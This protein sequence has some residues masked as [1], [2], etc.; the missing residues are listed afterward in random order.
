MQ[1]IHLKNIEQNNNLKININENTDIISSQKSVSEIPEGKIE[2][3]I[4]NPVKNQLKNTEQVKENIVKRPQLKK[5]ESSGLEIK[6]FKELIEIA[7]R[8][9]ELELKYDLE[10]NINLVSFTK[11]KININF[12]EKLNKNFIKNLTGK[13]FDWTGER[14]I[15]SLSKEEGE[16]T[17]YEKEKNRKKETLIKEKGN[18]TSKE[19]FS[20]FPDAKL[21]EVSEE[22]A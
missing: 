19:L 18:K 2:K 20:A 5:N 11:G 12:N 16:N 13:L 21:I 10:R 1:L 17:I 6:N 4:N 7:T 8:E 15:I 22:D 9:G 3:K 14:W